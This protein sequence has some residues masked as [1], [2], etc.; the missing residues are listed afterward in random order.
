MA[1]E[2][3]DVFDSKSL[4]HS[5]G[6]NGEILMEGRIWGSRF[7]VGLEEVLLGIHHHIVARG[8]N[9]S[10]RNF[11]LEKFADKIMPLTV[12]EKKIP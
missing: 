8:R 3:E 4:S 10:S 9:R 12:A 1:R 6:I 2:A 5:L 7:N 11:L